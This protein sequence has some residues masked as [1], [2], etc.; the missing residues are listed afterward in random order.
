MTN[1]HSSA[2]IQ[3]PSTEVGVLGWLK[4][5]LFNSK[6]SAVVT[7]VI[8]TILVIAIWLAL[9]WAVYDAR[10]GVITTNMRLFMVGLYPQDD[11]WRVWLAMAVLSV[12]SGLSAGTWRTGSI[13]IM[14]IMLA[15]GQLT[16]ALLAVVSGLGMVGALAL[17]ANAVLVFVL[18]FAAERW[19]VPRRWL[20]IGWL[21]STVLV[22]VLLYGFG[23]AT[24]LPAV[25][26]RVWG[27]LLLT[28]TLSVVSILLSFPIGVALAVGRRSSL[29]VVRL[30]STAFIE[31]VRAVPLITILFMATLLVPLFLPE[32]IRIDNVLRAMAGLTVFTAAYVA[33]NVR[34]GLRAIPAGQVEAAQAIGLRG[35]QMNISSCC[36]RRY[37]SRSRPTWDSS[38][39]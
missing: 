28:I 30:L 23:E 26:P 12:L 5:N 27:E 36:R 7:I 8:G 20:V 29:P 37:A 32:N 38:S 16:I 24:P 10:W 2:E 15:A 21:A 34:G 3:P 39:V 33:E 6:S 1:Q 31:V 18:M 19:P 25:S 17:V 14:A 4:H 35:W 22:V 13:R 9:T 11:I